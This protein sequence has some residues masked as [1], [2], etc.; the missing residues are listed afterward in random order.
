MFLQGAKKR[1]K[2][3]FRFGKL[4]ISFLRLYIYLKFENI[5][6]KFVGDAL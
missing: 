1:E 3:T 4:Y 6:S 5:V 2:C